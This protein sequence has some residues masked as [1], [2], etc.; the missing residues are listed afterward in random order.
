MIGHQT[1][2]RNALDITSIILAGSIILVLLPL[3]VTVCVR[4]P[5]LA[6]SAFWIVSIA[7]MSVLI[8]V[9]A[10]RTLDV[11]AMAAL[12][13]VL[14]IIFT[15]ITKGRV[16]A[17]IDK[18]FMY[19]HL[20]YGMLMIISLAWTTA[21]GYGINKVLRFNVFSTIALAAPMILCY[22][23]RNIRHVNTALVVIGLFTALW[24]VLFPTYMYG[25]RWQL[26]QTAFEGNPLNSAYVMA[27]AATIAAITL[28]GLGLRKWSGTIKMI[29]L[30]SV[31]VMLAAIYRT[32][33]RAMFMQVFVGVGI[34]IL[35]TGSRMRWAYR[36]LMVISI[37]A[38]PILLIS[39]GVHVP[40]SRV[41]EA[42]TSPV[43]TFM[44]AGARLGQW[45][46]AGVHGWE[47]PLVG[48]A[49]GSF[50]MDL[51]SVDKRM[52]PHNLILEAF[53]EHGL[54][55]VGILVAF[56]IVPF[57]RYVSWRRFALQ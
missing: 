33:S 35:I 25:A 45:R 40:E 49:T 16:N 12:I 9:P 42:I 52:F 2:E 55:G 26:R 34:W 47:R 29:C 43:E 53:Y 54:L 15:Y 36:V 28:L 48:H 56:L 4:W 20:A 32:G 7:K 23:P 27:V 5:W 1:E 11:T 41:A 39:T 30:L 46:F 14:T 17:P 8:H 21:P 6:L 44:S 51:Y 19:L 24:V 57:Y 50:A 13:I 10:L 3:I 37:I 38:L 31:P 22:Y 18:T